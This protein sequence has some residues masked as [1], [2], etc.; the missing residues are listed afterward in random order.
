MTSPQEAEAPPEAPLK[1]ALADPG[2][3][4]GA[5]VVAVLLLT[6][7]A[8]PVLALLIGHGPNEQYPDIAISDAGIPVGPDQQFWLGADSLGRDVLVRVIFGARISV[9]IGVLSTTVAMVIGVLVGLAAGYL[10]GWVDAALSELTNVT[11]AFP[12]LLTALSVAALNRAPGGAVFVAPAVVVVVIISLFSWTYFA[13]VVRAVV[14]D[15]TG[16]TFVKAAIGAGSP[17]RWILSREILPNILPAVVVYWAVQLP[18]NIMAEA[19]LSYLGVGI[20]A[21]EASWGQMIADAQSSGL[22]SVRPLILIAPCAALFVTVLGFNLLSTRLRAYLDPG[23]L[24]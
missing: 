8:A 6:A 19:T 12:M 17:T 7:A 20:R 15:V 21:P 10:R 22:Y 23:R 24:G 14:I 13:R 16:A 18:T 5:G 1:Q 11:M 4:L 2:L 3:R 9:S